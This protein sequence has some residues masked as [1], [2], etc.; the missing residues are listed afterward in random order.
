MRLYQ[1]KTFCTAKETVTSV[2]TQSTE[3]VK[4]LARFSSDKGFISRTCRELK[5]KTK[6]KTK[7]PSNT[8]ATNA[9]I[10]K[11]ENEIDSSQKKYKRLTNT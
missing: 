9:P 8:K 5:K 1:I 3:W 4:I 10:N 2:K 7:N 11:W 6:T